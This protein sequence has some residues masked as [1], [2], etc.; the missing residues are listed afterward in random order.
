[1]KHRVGRHARPKAG[2]RAGKAA[3]GI[4]RPE[5]PGCHGPRCADGKA[6]ELVSI[7]NRRK[8]AQAPDEL[9]ER[10]RQQR[11]G[12]SVD[13][14]EAAGE[15]RRRVDGDGG[16]NE[17]SPILGLLIRR[18]QGQ[19]G[20]AAKALSSNDMLTAGSAVQEVQARTQDR[21][22]AAPILRPDGHPPGGQ[23]P[24]SAVRRVHFQGA[25]R[26]LRLQRRA[27]AIDARQQQQNH[28][29]RVGRGDSGHFVLVLRRHSHEGNAPEPRHVLLGPWGIVLVG[30]IPKNFS[31]LVVKLIAVTSELQPRRQACKSSAVCWPHERE[32]CCSVQQQC[33]GQ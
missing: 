17:Q 1:M 3:H 5:L 22:K 8:E 28:I 30:E 10:L 6:L 7:W 26:Q 15:R 29:I 32:R 31:H 19:R 9:V 21:G 20:E 33:Q 18:C 2:D 25:V 11:Q 23:P 12:G 24:R 14:P 13:G 16:A 27:L 4:L